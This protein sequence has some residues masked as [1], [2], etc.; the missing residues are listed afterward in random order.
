[1]WGLVLGL[2]LAAAKPLDR[3][4]WGVWVFSIFMFVWEMRVSGWRSALLR[5]AGLQEIDDMDGFQ[6]QQRLAVLL[7]ALGWQAQE[8]KLSH[9][10]G[11]DLVLR[12][13]G[14][15]VTVQACFPTTAAITDKATSATDTTRAASVGSLQSGASAI[16]PHLA[17]ARL[18]PTPPK[19][20]VPRVS[21]AVEDAPP[22]WSPT[23]CGSVLRPWVDGP[24]Q[25]PVPEG[26]PSI[27]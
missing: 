24:S 25:E 8:M 9:D 17:T 6:F 11:A 1:M 15:V 14:E 2:V 26:L 20:A 19:P 22:M 12:R 16:P 3:I 27:V 10:Y 13:C 21:A 23:D 7:R 5:Q 4:G 18:A